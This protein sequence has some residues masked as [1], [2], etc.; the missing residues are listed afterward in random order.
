MDDVL[1]NRNLCD[2]SND[3][4]EPNG[5]LLVKSDGSSLLDQEVRLESAGG[6]GED[7]VLKVDGRSESSAV[8]H[9]S[10]NDAPLLGV[11]E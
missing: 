5:R 1:E 9:C 11:E 3:E 2:D 6:N 10:F 4:D 7:V 8:F